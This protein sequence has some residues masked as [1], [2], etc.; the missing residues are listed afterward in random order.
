MQDT[1]S[2]IISIL[3]A[4]ALFAHSLESFSHNLEAQGSGRLAKYLRK[5]SNSN[6]KV[7]GA[8]LLFTAI[9]Q[10]SS[11]VIS[12]A[13]GFVD[14]GYL[15][16]SSVLP[17][18][19]GSNLGTTSTAWLV[20]FNLGGIGGTIVVVGFILS[21]FHG[22]YRI[23]GKSL[24]YLGLILFSLD[25]ISNFLDPIKESPVIIE[26]LGAIDNPILGI[27]L[28][29]L[30]TVI[31]QSSS[32]AVG[33]TVILVAQGILPIEYSIAIVVGTNVGTT[34]TAFLAALKLGH[35][36]K[37]SAVMNLSINLFGV[38]LYLITY[39]WYNAFIVSLPVNVS[40]QVAFAHL[41]FN[42]F[43]VLVLLPFS[44]RITKLFFPLDV[45]VQ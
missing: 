31:A 41:I 39:K 4:I 22:S 29:F 18:L 43:M 33:L 9:L 44:K 6:L 26:A 16:A 45:E 1:V 42:V 14:A 2:L 24:F 32:L 7:F 15:T 10:S 37:R 38:L 19:L 23:I 3:A 13:I 27:L 36:A 30:I 28:G 8:S 25:L 21:Y 40:Y 17:M 35:V 11:A 34:S 12:M 20:S 5:L